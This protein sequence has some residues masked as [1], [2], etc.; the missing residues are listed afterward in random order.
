MSAHEPYLSLF[1]PPR[2]AAHTDSLARALRWMLRA[3]A[4]SKAS[5]VLPIFRHDHWTV[6][7]ICNASLWRERYSA[8]RLALALYEQQRRAH[9][10]L[11]AAWPA[12]LNALKQGSAPVVAYNTPEGL[13]C[14]THAPAG[15]AGPVTLAATPA[16]APSLRRAYRRAC[17]AVQLLYNGDCCMLLFD[18]FLSTET[19]R[20][21]VNS[22]RPVYGATDNPEFSAI[23]S[24]LDYLWEHAKHNID[25]NDY[26]RA[27]K[28]L[29]YSYIN[30][31]YSQCWALQRHRK[32]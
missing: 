27:K 3:D 17:A 32:L 10:R 24:N 22:T 1:P 9:A 18:S 15:A 2:P 11:V 16:P 8:A 20:N 4:F 6:L 23:A 21:V 31:C 30:E 13:L 26:M 12:V 29:V 14:P 5:L 19:R 7:V 25:A 28:N